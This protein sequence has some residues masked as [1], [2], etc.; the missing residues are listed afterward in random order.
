MKVSKNRGI[1]DDG[2]DM[3]AFLFQIQSHPTECLK[4]AGEFDRLS[5][6]QNRAVGE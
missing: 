1:P 3:L 6:F 5:D 2:E 4:P